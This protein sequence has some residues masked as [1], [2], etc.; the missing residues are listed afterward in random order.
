MKGFESDEQ[1]MVRDPVC[2]MEIQRAGARSTL[3]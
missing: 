1:E 2:G 3:R